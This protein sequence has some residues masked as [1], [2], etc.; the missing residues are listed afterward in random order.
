MFKTEKSLCLATP[1]QH[2]FLLW[3]FLL[4]ISSATR[5][6]G[7]W[8]NLLCF[9]NDFGWL[10]LFIVGNLFRARPFSSKIASTENWGD[11]EL[12]LHDGPEAEAL[13][14]FLGGNDRSTLMWNAYFPTGRRCPPIH[15]RSPIHL[16]VRTIRL[17]NDVL[18]QAGIRSPK[19]TQKPEQQKNDGGDWNMNNS[20][21]W[22]V[23]T[24]LFLFGRLKIYFQI[25]GLIVTKTLREI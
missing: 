4:G 9:A 3:D 24:G 7:Y 19:A 17:A 8:W 18:H 6:K 15:H 1:A 11:N 20:R 22:W 16:G 12:D 21:A 2:F 5:K 23:D 25:G 10:K 14:V 13:Q